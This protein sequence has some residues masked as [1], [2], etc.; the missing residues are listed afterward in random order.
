MGWGGSGEG[1]RGEGTRELA[2]LVATAR[3]VARN[4]SAGVEP[5]PDRV[6]LRWST[7]LDD[8]GGGRRPGS[9]GHPAAAGA[10]LGNEKP[11]A[12][13]RG[14]REGKG[15]VRSRGLR[16]SLLRGGSPKRIACPLPNPSFGLNAGADDSTTLTTTTIEPSHDAT[17]SWHRTR[18]V[19]PESSA[20]NRACPTLFNRVPSPRSRGPAAF[21]HFSGTSGMIPRT[22][23]QYPHFLVPPKQFSR[24]GEKLCGFLPGTLGTNSRGCSPVPP[25]RSR[26][27]V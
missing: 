11:P 1:R 20:R 15:L 25:R 17:A 7:R 5:Y 18:D 9:L 14:R 10:T 27:P 8:R 23:K 16:V 24:S 4:R 26:R 21:P 22:S 3:A 2:A 19:L 6:A 12:R 13:G